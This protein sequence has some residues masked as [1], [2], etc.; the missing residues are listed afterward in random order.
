MIDAPW[1]SLLLE[2]R[3]DGYYRPGKIS[4]S[5]WTA[6]LIV[7]NFKPIT[8]L[9]KFKHDLHEVMAM[10]RVDPR[11]AQDDVLGKGLPYG[12]LATE[13]ALSINSQRIGGV[14]LCV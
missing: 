13:L 7:D 11:G 4:C 12:K 9:S 2:E 8:L 6:P 1:Q 5:S 10:R 14:S 3:S